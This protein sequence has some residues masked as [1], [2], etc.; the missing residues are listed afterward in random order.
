MELV[1]EVLNTV[2]LQRTEEAKRRKCKEKRK[3]EDG[4]SLATC[5]NGNFEIVDVT[6]FAGLEK[7]ASSNFAQPSLARTK[8][9]RS[10]EV[11][12]AP[13]KRPL[14]S[15][16]EIR[17][18]K[19]ERRKC[20]FE[21]EEKRKREEREFELEKL[22]LE[23]ESFNSAGSW[24]SRPKIDFLSMIPKFDQI[25]NDISLYLIL[26]ERQAQAADVPKEVWASQLLSLLPYKIAQLVAREGVGYFRGF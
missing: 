26:F 8:R 23:N 15:N 24:Y 22:K 14:L 17:I 1:K 10:E 16:A 9:W 18:E 3:R 7:D 25:D 4:I 5:L 13:R 6:H 12:G 20:E 19:A 11:Y 21:S 2:I